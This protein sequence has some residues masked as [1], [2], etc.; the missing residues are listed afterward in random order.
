MPSSGTRSP[1]RHYDDGADLD[2]VGIDR[3]DLSI[4]LDIG[5]FG[6]DIH[7]L[8]DGVAR[9]ADR[10]VFEEIARIW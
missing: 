1:G 8:G 5:L 10:I 2:L 6:A 4:T 7:H 3:F 9:F